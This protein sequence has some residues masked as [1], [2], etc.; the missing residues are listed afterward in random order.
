MGV[1]ARLSGPEPPEGAKRRG[2]RSEKILCSLCS[3]SRIAYCWV[4]MKTVLNL[5]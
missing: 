1:E 5:L 2:V 3:G 4:V